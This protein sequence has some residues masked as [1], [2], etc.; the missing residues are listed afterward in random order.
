MFGLFIQDRT[1]KDKCV[2]GT[3][4]FLLKPPVQVR[5]RVY[6]CAR[7]LGRELKAFESPS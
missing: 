1:K 3:R 7:A 5:H 6:S 2:L 4:D